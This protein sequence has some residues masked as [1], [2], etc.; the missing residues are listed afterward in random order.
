MDE[1]LII[2]KG[3]KIRDDRRGG[4]ERTEEIRE[5]RKRVVTEVNDG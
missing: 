1:E 2:T 3:L 5:T 4:S